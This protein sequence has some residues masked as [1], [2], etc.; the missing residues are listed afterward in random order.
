MSKKIELDSNFFID[1]RIDENGEQI[2]DDSLKK[3]IDSD[4]I[5]D[6]NW[7]G[8]MLWVEHIER[9]PMYIENV[10]LSKNF[11]A[12]IAT[13]LSDLMKESFN[14][15]NP[16]LEAET[17]CLRI[18]ILHEDTTDTGTSIS[19]R[20]T[21][22]HRV[23]SKEK[24]YE[25]DYCPKELDDFMEN[26]VKAGCNIII[27]GLPG[28]G[29]TEYLKLLTSYINPS[30]KAFTIEDN[31]EI[32]YREINPGKLCTAIKVNSR[33][34]YADAIKA[35]L[36][37]YAKWII[38]SEARGKE[39]EN[40]MEAFSTGCHGITTIHTDDVRKI[41]DRIMNMPNAVMNINKNDIYSFLDIA[42]FIVRNKKLNIWR[43]EQAAFLSRYNEENKLIVF[44]ENGKFLTN[45]IPPD[46][47]RKF[48]LNKLDNPL[49]EKSN[50]NDFLDDDNSY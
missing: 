22:P 6:I 26:A 32:R 50:D 8:E 27:G 13:K 9:G 11:V 23:L 14:Q 49:K 7:D 39:I 19:I 41:P 36:R 34:T 38:L 40:L 2:I 37:Q 30:E 21:P 43:I 15:Y 33:F 17:D 4:D 31:I 20:K 45:E 35:A 25:K 24:M 42:L 46:I 29:K 1:S 5:T 16:L 48:E 3:L 28:A 44:Y 12:K 18:S 47:E 10:K